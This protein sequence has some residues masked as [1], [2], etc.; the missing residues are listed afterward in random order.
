MAGISGQNYALGTCIKGANGISQRSRIKSK[1]FVAD[2]V[3]LV[4]LVV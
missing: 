3:F 1:T 4:Y 2:L